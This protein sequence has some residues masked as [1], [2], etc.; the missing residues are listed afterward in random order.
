MKNDR[1]LVALMVTAAM[2]ALAAAIIAPRLGNTPTRDPVPVQ[3][4]SKPATPTHTN[5]PPGYCLQ[6]E[7]GGR[8]RA[9]FDNGTPLFDVLSDGTKD[10]AIKRAWQQYEHQQRVAAEKWERCPE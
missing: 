1:I 8:Y 5:M 6:R 2:C 3:Q 7:A 4:H 9:A 10:Y